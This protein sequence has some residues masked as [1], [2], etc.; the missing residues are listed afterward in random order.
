M[1]HVGQQ[2]VCISVF[3]HP[4]P[5]TDGFKFIVGR[6]YTI[7]DVFTD[8]SWGATCGLRFEE[9]GEPGPQAS[10]HSDHFR[11][12]KTTSIDIFRKIV[13]DLPIELDINV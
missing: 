1:F 6:I 13:A 8:P 7:R 10:W 12:V 4:E 2:V 5:S 9:I 11:P 3:D